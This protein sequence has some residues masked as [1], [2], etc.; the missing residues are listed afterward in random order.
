MAEE[1]FSGR[2]VTFAIAFTQ[3]ACGQLW[4]VIELAGIGLRP[5]ALPLG[6]E[7][8]A[9]GLALWRSR[10][11]PAAP[12]EV[13]RSWLVGVGCF[14][15]WAALYFIAG[16]TFDPARAT[17]FD[18]PILARAPLVPE[19]T[20]IYLGVHPFGLLPF[21][22]LPDAT[23]VRRHVRG[24]IAIVAVS[25]LVWF[26]WP[27]MLPHPPVPTDATTFGAF[28]LRS[29]HGVDPEA[30]CFPSA[31]C[32][33]AVYGAIG[34]GFSGSRSLFVWGIASAIA[35]CVTTVLT[36]QHYV[37]DVAAGAALALVAGALVHRRRA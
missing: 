28:L 6:I 27:V 5:P 13:A 12:P 23:R 17:T 1:R 7:G 19:L 36:R 30:N 11:T 21:C 22:V 32:A 31:H 16:R 15:L 8:V 34:L 3:V 33:I 26:A 10:R 24:A 9:I 25:S 2:A 35:I 37:A 29:L 14:A 18:D 20:G 4:A